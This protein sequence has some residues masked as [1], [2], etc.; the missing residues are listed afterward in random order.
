[1][2]L[3]F[4]SLLCAA[5]LRKA[6]GMVRNEVS[7]LLFWRQ[8]EELQTAECSKPNGCFVLSFAELIESEDQVG[9]M[10]SNVL[11][12]FKLNIKN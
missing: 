1:M 4:F 6:R 5:F 2:H 9:I 8:I 11:V 10:R 12:H 7:H 3:G